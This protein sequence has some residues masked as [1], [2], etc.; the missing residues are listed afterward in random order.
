MKKLIVLNHKMS[1]IYDDLYNYIER[2]NNIDTDND[3][4][5][6]P[7][8]IYL[9]AFINSSDKND[10]I[11]NN[12]DSLSSKVYRVD[13]N[14]GFNSNYV[15]EPSGIVDDISDLKV[16]NPTIV[17][18]KLIAALD[19][20]I[21]P[22]LC[23]GEGIED[24]YRESLPRML[25]RYLK[26]I[27]NIEFIIFAYEPIYAIG[28]GTLPTTE[29]IEEVTSFIG[30]YL[31][32]K[33]YKKPVLLYGGSIDDSNIKDIINIPTI[34]GVLLGDISSDIRVVEKVV[35]EIN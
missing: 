29:K 3:I 8:N 10:S 18:S 9:E 35:E 21:F 7:S 26:D 30:K 19:A 5:V 34:D 4:I 25:D 2:L 31:E 22:I 28:T 1:L 27:N 15:G 20:N 23:F 33:Y 16:E 24:D 17:N 32:D 6:C 12:V 13:L 14:D 11:S